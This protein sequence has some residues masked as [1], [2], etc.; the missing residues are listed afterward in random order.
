[1]SVASKII[2]H[3]GEAPPDHEAEQRAKDIALFQLDVLTAEA[4]CL[5]EMLLTA[6]GLFTDQEERVER[7]TGELLSIL[8]AKYEAIIDGSSRQDDN[9]FAAVKRPTDR[10]QRRRAYFSASKHKRRD[11]L[12]KIK[13]PQSAPGARSIEDFLT[14][15]RRFRQRKLDDGT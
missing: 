1:M 4:S 10:V 9:F 3:R 2:L 15:T 13:T 11:A 5:R 14:N 12:S 7:A 6:S 8:E